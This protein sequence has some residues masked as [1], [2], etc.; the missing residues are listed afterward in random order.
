MFFVSAQKKNYLAAYSYYKNYF[1]RVTAD[2]AF[3]SGYKK[4]KN[5]PSYKSFYKNDSFIDFYSKRLESD[6]VT[7]VI[8][9]A[10]DLRHENPLVHSSAGLIDND[11][12]SREIVATVN[13]L[14]ELIHNYIAKG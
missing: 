10:Q 5:K 12:S 1:D 6:K 9:K 3:Q 4:K 2:I 8:E 7:T 14:E 11:S 13:S